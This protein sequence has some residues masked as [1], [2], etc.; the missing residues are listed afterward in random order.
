MSKNIG[1]IFNKH[2]YNGIDFSVV[3]VNTDH[4]NDDEKDAHKRKLERN[5][6]TFEG[7]NEKIT[8]SCLDTENITPCLF[9]KHGFSLETMYPGLLCGSG[10]AHESKMTGEFKLGYHFDFTTGLPVIPGSSIKGVLRSAFKYPAYIVEKLQEIDNY[11]IQ[12]EPDVEELEKNIF[13]GELNNHSIPTYKCDVFFDAF[14]VNT[15]EQDGKF[16]DNDYITPHTKGPLKNPTPL[17]FLKVLPRVSYVF[18][19]RL[20]DIG[21]KASHKEELFKQILRDLGLGAKTNVGY[22]QLDISAE[23][24]REEERQK[25]AL[26]KEKEKLINDVFAS[27]ISELMSAID[28]EDLKL[29]TDLN[30]KLQEYF[31]KNKDALFTE[32]SDYYAIEEKYKHFLLEQNQIRYARL[33]NELNGFLQKDKIDEARNIFNQIETIQNN[34]QVEK[35]PVYGYAELFISAKDNIEKEEWSKAKKDLDNLKQKVPQ[36]NTFYINIERLLDICK[37]NLVSILPDDNT[38]NIDTLLNVQRASQINDKLIR[39]WLKELGKREKDLKEPFIRNTKVQDKLKEHIIKLKSE[40]YCDINKLNTANHKEKNIW[41][42]RPVKYN[43]I[44]K[45][46]KRLIGE[47]KAGS[48]FS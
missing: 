28:N 37:D 20:S 13:I 5:K 2:Y 12:N 40:V 39:Q 3:G 46:L 17:Q 47:T 7:W 48:L 27:I 25:L 44:Y 23:E 30:T 22:G 1:L 34:N 8:E 31:N 4:L 32:V 26:Q 36:E 19:F 15:Q 24:K 42:K 38:M 41:E 43:D 21:I 33:C 11:Y 16:L 14:P 9:N 6:D 29:S 18:Q 35:S 10:Y 45:P